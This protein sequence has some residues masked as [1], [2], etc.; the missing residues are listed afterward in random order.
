M[1]RT[2]KNSSVEQTHL[3]L[4]EGIDD[5][6]F[7]EALLKQLNL[8]D[9]EI[10]PIGIGRA[11]K[12]RLGLLTKLSGFERVKSIGIIR[13]ADND[14]AAAFTSISQALKENGLSAPASYGY[15]STETPITCIMIMPDGLNGQGMLE[16]LCLRAI[17]D[18]PAMSCINKYFDCLH[19][20]DIFQRKVDEDKAK[21]H[22]YLS[23]RE[24]PDKRLGE[25]ALAG[26]WPFD[27]EVFDGVK[28]F[29]FEIG[30]T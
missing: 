25:S 18:N 3:L 28:W 29:L 1:V 2:L 8:N 12:E 9:V 24:N 17:K 21:V 7:F 22:A 16:S 11:F 13:D 23:S 6:I 4:V 19:K 26:Y 14:P 30:N 15:R 5:A 10:W 27:N 20:L